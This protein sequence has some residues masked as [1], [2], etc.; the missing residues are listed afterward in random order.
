MNQQGGKGLPSIW[1]L[2][3]TFGLVVVSNLFMAATE[4]SKA[5]RD[6]KS[7][8]IKATEESKDSEEA[9]EI[10]DFAIRKG[11][12]SIKISVFLQAVVVV[13]FIFGRW[14][15]KREM[16]LRG[17]VMATCVAYS[18]YLPLRIVSCGLLLVS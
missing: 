11:F 10:A 15:I 4:L 14:I 12:A 2:L 17:V 18:L 7:A 5:A 13:I 16:T 1:L 6:S 9:K 8:L 3:A